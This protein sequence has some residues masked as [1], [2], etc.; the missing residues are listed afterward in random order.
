VEGFLRFEP[1]VVMSEVRL[2]AKVR[3]LSESADRSAGR[4][5]PLRVISWHS[6]YNMRKN[7]RGNPSLTFA[8]KF[9]LYTIHYINM[10]TFYR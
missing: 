6:P 2:A 10:A 7:S 9:Q 3:H 1:R 8:E 5:P 4:A